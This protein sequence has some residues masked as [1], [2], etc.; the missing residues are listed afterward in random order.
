MC[1]LRAAS[2][3]DFPLLICLAYGGYL[4]PQYV[5]AVESN[6]FL[7]LDLFFFLLSSTLILSS[8]LLSYLKHIDLTHQPLS[9]RVFTKSQRTKVA[10]LAYFYLA[11]GFFSN[12]RLDSMSAELA[13]M[14]GQWTG[15]ATILV[16]L[17]SFTAIGFAL[18]LFFNPPNR[19]RLSWPGIAYALWVLG[20]QVIFGGRRG[21]ALDLFFIFCVFLF[22]HYGWIP[23]KY[24]A[25]ISAIMFTLFSLAISEV[26]NSG[27]VFA[28]S[29]QDYLSAIQN[30]PPHFFADVS[31]ALFVI[32]ETRST[33]NFSHVFSVTDRLVERLIPGQ[34]V[35]RELKASLI[36]YEGVSLSENHFSPVGS[37]RTGI[38]STFESLFV[39]GFVWFIIISRVLRR[40]SILMLKGSTLGAVMF[41]LLLRSGV[42]AIGFQ[43][44][45]FFVDLCVLYLA[46]FV[47]MRL[48]ISRDPFLLYRNEYFKRRQICGNFSGA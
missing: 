20:D 17:A 12:R 38:G 10:G 14:G 8:V 41:A 13:L 9:K 23:K 44:A 21:P 2:A 28:L 35:G 33:F 27:G 40:H 29:L 11:I 32:Q 42:S 3:I 7:R 43:H 19:S 22:F 5:A 48:F 4:L 25:L 16:F 46:V 6:L 36:F 31:N 15:I 34:L 18:L 47:P 24:L 1:Y 45:N 30:V 26:R 39:F 37:T